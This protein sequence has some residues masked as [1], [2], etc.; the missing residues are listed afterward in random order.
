MTEYDSKRAGI[1]GGKFSIKTMFK[2]G[3]K[4]VKVNELTVKMEVMKNELNCL[5]K[6]MIMMLVNTNYELAE[7]RVRRGN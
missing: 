5:E 7:F 2:S 6:M 4:D 1:E 3:S